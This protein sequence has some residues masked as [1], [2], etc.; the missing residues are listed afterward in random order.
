M[1][2]FHVTLCQTW[3]RQQIDNLYKFAE[4]AEVYE[5]LKLPPGSAHGRK[6]ICDLDE[7]GTQDP[8]VGYRG[9]LSLLHNVQTEMGSSQHPFQ[10]VPEI[11]SSE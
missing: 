4:R 8:A 9:N 3:L 1:T 5:A 11:L 7:T 2:I 6:Y 10:R